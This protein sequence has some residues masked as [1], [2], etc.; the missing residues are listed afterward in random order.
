[1]KDEQYF[2]IKRDLIMLSI[3]KAVK[4]L[5]VRFILNSI[6]TLCLI[7]YFKHDKLSIIIIMLICLLLLSI[8]DVK[9]ILKAK[10]DLKE[11]G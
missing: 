6:V 4:S 2:T 8:S 5:I 10:K 9:K 11:L 7:Y 3:D 1:M